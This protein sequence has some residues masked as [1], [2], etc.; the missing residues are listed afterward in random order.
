MGD[1]ERYEELD[2]L[3][4]S[5]KESRRMTDEEVQQVLDVANS[6]VGWDRMVGG[7]TRDPLIEKFQTVREEFVDAIRSPLHP[8]ETQ[9][10]NE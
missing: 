4:S 9:I 3:E 6:T 2:F 7:W 1:D 8:F 10:L 5:M